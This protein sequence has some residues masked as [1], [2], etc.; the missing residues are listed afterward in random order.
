MSEG[1]RIA[2]TTV[3]PAAPQGATPDDRATEFTAVDANA[4]RYSGST[5]VVEAYAAIWAVLMI[6]IYFLWRKQASLAGR[7]DDLE[8]T[9]DRAAEAADRKAKAKAKAS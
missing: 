6:W 2:P 7:L 4:E 5:L 3:A 9:I 1:F 8:R